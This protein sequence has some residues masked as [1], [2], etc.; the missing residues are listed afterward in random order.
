MHE[1]LK[2]LIPVHI[3]SH[4]LDTPPRYWLG[5]KTLVSIQQKKINRVVKAVA[6]DTASSLSEEKLLSCDAGVIQLYRYPGLATSSAKT[7]LRKAQDK[8][9]DKIS[10]IDGELCYNISTKEPLTTE[11]ASTLAWLLRETFE[12]ELLTPQSVFSPIDKTGS[13]VEV[14]Y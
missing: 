11:E 4:K 2:A 3:R 7:L 13:V 14:G 1:S 5:I 10:G 6:T 12:P 8:V 9:S